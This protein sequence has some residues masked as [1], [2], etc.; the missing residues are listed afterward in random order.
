M[1]GRNI[2]KKERPDVGKALMFTKEMKEHKLPQG[3]HQETI[4]LSLL[5]FS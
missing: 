3:E 2:K 4:H 5:L 1:S